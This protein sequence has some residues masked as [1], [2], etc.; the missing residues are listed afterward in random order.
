MITDKALKEIYYGDRFD[1]LVKYARL[2]GFNNNVPEE[3]GYVYAKKKN[4]KNM[5]NVWMTVE[6]GVSYK[7]EKNIVQFNINIP[8]HVARQLNEQIGKTLEKHDK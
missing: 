5:V 4:G 6:N 2:V 8:F 3:H 7:G 1:G